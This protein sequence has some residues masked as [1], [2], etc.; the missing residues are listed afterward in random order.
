MDLQQSSSGSN[1]APNILYALPPGNPNV[2][3]FEAERVDRLL[4]DSFQPASELPGLLVRIISVAEKYSQGKALAR[5]LKID[6]EARFEPSPVPTQSIG[7]KIAYI[8]KGWASFEIEGLGEARL[9]KGTLICLPPRNR[10]RILNASPDFEDIEFQLPLLTASLARTWSPDGPACA[11]S[12]MIDRETPDSFRAIPHFIGGVDRQF[13]IVKEMTGGAVNASMLRAN[14]P[15]IWDGTPWHM[16]HN[17]FYCVL[18][19]K[20][21]GVMRYEGA[22]DIELRTGDFLIQQGEVRHCEVIMSGDYENFVVDL[23]GAYP[24]TVLVYDKERETYKPM[25]FTSAQESAEAMA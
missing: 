24:T 8:L 7:I 14:P 22:G 4:A 6:P 13:P 11:T 2:P 23:P 20:G 15:H 10:H 5:M 1:E 12:A 3:P 18:K 17:D 9:E 19:A 16:H 25:M 21:G